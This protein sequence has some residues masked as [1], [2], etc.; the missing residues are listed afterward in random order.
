MPHPQP[1]DQQPRA[2]TD[3]LASQLGQRVLGAVHATV[4]QL[5]V[6]GLDGELIST[7]VKT[8]FTALTGDSASIK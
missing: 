3:A 2:I 1:T 7:A 8:Q 5:A 4:H 6:T